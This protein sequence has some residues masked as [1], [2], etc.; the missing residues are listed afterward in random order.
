MEAL[1]KH[2][3]RRL[4]AGLVALL[5]IGGTLFTVWW[6]EDTVSEMWLAEQSFY[7]PGLG[8]LA[9]LV[10]IYLIGL[11]IS[12]VLGR[13]AWRTVDRLLDD[14]PALG[15]LYR[16]LKQV[17]GYGEGRD[18][19]FERAVWVPAE[20]DGGWQ[21]GLVTRRLDDQ[22]VAVFVPGSPNPTAGRLLVLEAG[23]L[24]SAPITVNEAL[25]TLLA[26]G[27]SELE[28]PPPA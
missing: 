28:P 1:T 25:T 20:L 11:T 21:L 16:T 12:S 15:V 4:L 3:T 22:R 27:K 6:M 14:F 19:L 13:W 23:Q 17:L 26:L 7:F 5:P 18:A 9:V 2:V 24:R 8:L 10:A